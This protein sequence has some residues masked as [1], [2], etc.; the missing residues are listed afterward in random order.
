MLTELLTEVSIAI[1][2]GLRGTFAPLLR[3]SDKPIAIACFRLLTFPP[4]PALPERSV[5]CLHR[6]IAL[7]TDL[8][9]DS[10]YL[11]M[12]IQLFLCI[13][14]ARICNPRRE[15]P[16]PPRTVRCN[17]FHCLRVGRCSSGAH[18]SCFP[19]LTSRWMPRTRL[20]ITAAAS[21]R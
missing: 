18:I 2:F 7:L 13:R 19:W 1:H 12:T 21:M 14:C 17:I 4:S 9:A 5:P 20:G 10:P 6:R 15:Y 8:P 16:L 3:A 11:A